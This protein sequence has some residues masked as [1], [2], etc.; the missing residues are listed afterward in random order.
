PARAGPDAVPTQDG[1]L[2]GQVRIEVRGAPAHLPDVHVPAEPSQEDVQIA[3]GNALVEDMSQPGRARFHAHRHTS[4]EPRQLTARPVYVASGRAGPTHARLPH[5]PPPDPAQQPGGSGALV[6]MAPLCRRHLAVSL[7]RRPGEALK[8]VAR[9][10]HLGQGA[11]NVCAASTC[12]VTSCNTTSGPRSPGY[13]VAN[14]LPG[15]ARTRHRPQREE[16]EFDPLGTT[17]VIERL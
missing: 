1:Q 5:S 13:M 4:Q 3:R 15:Q 12:R 17:R 14:A 10:L 9:C 11:M 7:Q 2:L 16:L 6:S 8:L